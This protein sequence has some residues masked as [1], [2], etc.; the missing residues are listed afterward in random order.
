VALAVDEDVGAARDAVRPWLAFYLGA[1]GSR[2]KNFYVELAERAGHGP[3][4][5]ACQDAMLSGHREA[6]AAALSDE[7]V[8]AMAVATTSGGL[9]DRLA[10]LEACGVDTIVAVPLSSDRPR[11]VRLLAEAVG[12]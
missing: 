6:A 4:A 7:L 9:D 8:D 10:A 12:A 5:R 11:V 1:M 2:E 3:A